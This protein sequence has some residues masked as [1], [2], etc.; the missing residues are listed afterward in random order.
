M[1]PP[2]SPSQAALQ[3]PPTAHEVRTTEHLRAGAIWGTRVIAH[4]IGL[5]WNSLSKPH[6][7]I[8]IPTII[9]LL[10]SS[11]KYELHPQTILLWICRWTG[12]ENF[13][14]SVF[15]EHWCSGKTMVFE[16]LRQWASSSLGNVNLKKLKFFFPL[17]CLYFNSWWLLETS[18]KGIC[19]LPPGIRQLH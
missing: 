16:K 15:L 13:Q 14:F 8:H 11:P 2:S 9:A 19:L 4:R 1:L 6:K 7:K 5:S 10:N 3:P 12:V 17:S 18:I